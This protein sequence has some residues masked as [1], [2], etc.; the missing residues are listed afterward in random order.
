MPYK[1][2]F[3]TLIRK[4]GSV[5]PVRSHTPFLLK[6]SSPHNEMKVKSPHWLKQCRTGHFG[7]KVSCGRVTEGKE[8][9]L[10]PLKMLS[11][12]IHCS[13]DNRFQ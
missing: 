12:F 1:T 10:P 7:C 5:L 3:P 11:L 6:A 13:L 8:K 9:H 4:E 2:Y